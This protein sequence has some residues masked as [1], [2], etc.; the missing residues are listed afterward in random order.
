MLE[1]YTFL[2]AIC[3]LLQSLCVVFTEI[4]PLMKKKNNPILYCIFRDICTL[5]ISW[6]RSYCASPMPLCMDYSSQSAPKTDGFI[7]KRIEGE[8]GEGQSPT[9][10]K[11]ILVSPLLLKN[12]KQILQW[13]QLQRSVAIKQSQRAFLVAGQFSEASLTVQV[14]KKDVSQRQVLLTKGKF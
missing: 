4:H 10:R 7:Q 11:S 2:F 6:Y 13:R 9:L 3:N 8:I 1:L 5:L 12:P 14:K